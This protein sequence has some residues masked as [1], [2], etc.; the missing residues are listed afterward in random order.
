MDLGE[1]EACVHAYGVAQLVTQDALFTVVG[2]LQQVE[3]RRRSGKSTAGL[4]L[5]NGEEA[6]EDTAQGVS[7]VLERREAVS[8]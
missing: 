2:Q 6:S 3:A 4:L 1:L 8:S 5:A 7:S